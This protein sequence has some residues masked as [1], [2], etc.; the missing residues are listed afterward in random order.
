MVLIPPEL[1]QDT[2]PV[3][4]GSGLIC[5]VTG[6]GLPLMDDFMRARNRV[7]QWG[8]HPYVMGTNRSCGL[9]KTDMNFTLDRDNASYWRDVAMDPKSEW[10]SGQP[11]ATKSREDYPWIDYWWPMVQG[12]GSSAWG[13]AKVLLL[14]GYEKVLLAGVP[15]E[16]GP[17]A[18]NIYAPT[19]Q[20][21]MVTINSMRDRVKLDEW[22]H[23]HVSSMS[24]WT[25]EFLGG[26]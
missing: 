16:Q 24:G 26:P 19:F 23:P 1:R 11:G 5:I 14:M 13:A 17:Y 15:L 9:I 2:P 22:M 20:D 6:M 8:E 3:T 10:H 7:M 25:K 21:D 12:S 18:D 4:V